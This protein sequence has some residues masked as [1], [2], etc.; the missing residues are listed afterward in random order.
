MPIVLKSENLSLLEPSGPVQACTGS[1]L[2]FYKNI[3]NL[4]KGVIVDGSV[5]PKSEGRVRIMTLDSRC[6]VSKIMAQV[7]TVSNVTEY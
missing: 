1:A 6:C 2:P 4:L 5:V 3:N 7:S